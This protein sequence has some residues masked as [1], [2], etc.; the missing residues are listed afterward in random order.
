MEGLSISCLKHLA[1]GMTG[2]SDNDETVA[3]YYDDCCEKC[4][5]AISITDSVVSIG[6][7][8][9]LDGK[10]VKTPLQHESFSNFSGLI[11]INSGLK[12]KIYR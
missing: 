10:A 11:L 7:F 9:H 1:L 5:A 4:C 8:P 12:D 6:A 2:H 3:L